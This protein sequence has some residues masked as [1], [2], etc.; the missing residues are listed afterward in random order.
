MNWPISIFADEAAE[1]FQD[2][3]N[4]VKSEGFDAIEIRHANGRNIV[5]F[6][7]D[8]I[9]EINDSGFPV[10]CIGSPVNKI[11]Y[12]PAQ[13]Q[14]ELDKLKT[15]IEIAQQINCKR[16]RI[17][18]PEP[19]SRPVQNSEDYIAWLAPM[20]ELGAKNEVTILHENDG[21]FYGAYPDEAKHI[22]AELGSP[23]FKAIFDFS[24]CIL[25]GGNP[26][27]EWFPWI[28]PHLDV[29]HIKDAIHATNEIVPAGKGEG[30]ILDTFKLLTQN[31]WKGTLSI[32]PHLQNRGPYGAFS[33]LEF[34]Q[35]AHKSLKE[36]LAQA[37]LEVAQ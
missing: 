19:P 32:E 13:H 23:H 20:A 36:V 14:N 21:L 27:N 9:K 5:D 22:F 15:T 12:D 3:L 1:S 35:L 37:N 28:I 7:P 33:G 31:N 2:Q 25:I 24:N 34:C 17:F 29:L 10:H 11:K 6:T 30:R 8:D 16:I 4:F 18:S 26:Y